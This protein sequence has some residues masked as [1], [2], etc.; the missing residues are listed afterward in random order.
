MS[1]SSDDSPLYPTNFDEVQV[2]VPESPNLTF[3]FVIKAP[4]AYVMDSWNLPIADGGDIIVRT[5]GDT[6]R[7]DAWPGIAQD[8]ERTIKSLKVTQVVG[9]IHT[10]EDGDWHFEWK[11]GAPYFRMPFPVSMIMSAAHGK[12]T[13]SDGPG[14]NQTTVT[15]ESRHRPAIALWFSRFAIKASLPGLARLAPSRF[16]SKTLLGPRV[17]EANPQQ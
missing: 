5:E 15:V 13:L 12:A 6:Q 3:S 11:A 14:P 2:D 10:P 9:N 1:S 16:A 4:K 8:M 17:N 7:G